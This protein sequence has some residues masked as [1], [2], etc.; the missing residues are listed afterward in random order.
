M[1]IPETPLI[2]ESSK[3]NIEVS[4]LDNKKSDSDI[5]DHLSEVSSVFKEDSQFKSDESSSAL[6]DS[7]PAAKEITGLL[8]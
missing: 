1:L 6:D 2:R 8:G 5:I 4:K 3:N 7:L